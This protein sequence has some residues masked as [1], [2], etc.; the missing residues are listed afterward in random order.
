MVL[1][2]RSFRCGDCPGSRRVSCGTRARAGRRF[3]VF[4][5]FRPTLTDNRLVTSSFEFPTYPARLSDAERDKALSVLR[6]GV[7]MG[8]LSHGARRSVRRM[9]L[10]LA[11]RRPR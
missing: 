11:A 2:K 1:H 7:A 3:P 9:E 5:T 10:A 6:D 4:W 8:R